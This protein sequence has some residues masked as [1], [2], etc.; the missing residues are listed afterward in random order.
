[1]NPLTPSLSPSGGEGGR[2][3]G[4][5]VFGPENWAGDAIIAGYSRGKL[6]R[7][8]LVKTAAGYVAQTHL[9]ATL[10]ALTVDACVSP[11]GDLIVATHSGQP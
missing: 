10:Q 2:R 4:E 8:K 3:P 7:T 1:M 5:G 6:W 9:L 11:R